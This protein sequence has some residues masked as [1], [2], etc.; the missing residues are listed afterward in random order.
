MR[1]DEKRRKPKPTFKPHWTLAMWTGLTLLALIY[2]GCATKPAPNGLDGRPCWPAV[3]DS[4]T[5]ML[6]RASHTRWEIKAGDLIQTPDCAR[7]MSRDLLNDTYE[8]TR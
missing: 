4:E 8:L 7:E 2:A 1:Y 3:L 5:A 6:L